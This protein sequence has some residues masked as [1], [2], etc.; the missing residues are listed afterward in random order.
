M[1]AAFCLTVARAGHHQRGII[2][3]VNG[4]FMRTVVPELGTE[5][6]STVPAIFSMLF[7]TTSRVVM[8]G[9]RTS[10]MNEVG[11]ELLEPFDG[12]WRALNPPRDRAQFREARKQNVTC[13]AKLKG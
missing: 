8:I 3:S 12:F 2:A 7:L 9:C 11:A 13:G 1:Y 10:D 5:E 6:T 4:I